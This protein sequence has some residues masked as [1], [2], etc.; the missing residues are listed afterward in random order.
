MSLFEHA[1]NGDMAGQHQTGHVGADH[2]LDLI[3]RLL[4]ETMGTMRLAGVIDPDID[5]AELRRG[6]VPEPLKLTVVPDVAG[7][8]DD[9]IAA[10]L[11]RQFTDYAFAGGFCPPT[12]DSAVALLNE[13]SYQRKANAAGA[14][15][16]HHVFH[17]PAPFTAPS[18]R[19]VARPGPD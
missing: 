18:I 1:V 6:V 5:A 16:N 2:G 9:L 12:D 17:F 8:S 7:D 10:K 13:L 15:G 3:S 14:P 19:P 4:P 11:T